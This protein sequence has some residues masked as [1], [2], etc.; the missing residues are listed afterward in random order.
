[1]CAWVRGV[2]DDAT[3]LKRLGSNDTSWIISGSRLLPSYRT[4]DLQSGSPPGRKD[5]AASPRRRV[6]ESPSRASP[7]PLLRAQHRQAQ[8]CD[9][10][11]NSVGSIFEGQAAA[12]RFCD[13]PA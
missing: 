8:F 6:A 1:M 7:S 2:H 4:A 13:L 5:V 10:P 3:S 12:V 11:D 9:A